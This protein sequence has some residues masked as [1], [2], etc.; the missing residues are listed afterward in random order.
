MP[1][2]LNNL[3]S[4][5]RT[6]FTTTLKLI[7]LYKQCKLQNRMVEEEDSSLQYLWARPSSCLRRITSLNWH[8]IWK[9][10]SKKD[11]LKL[12][13]IS[14]RVPF[15][16]RIQSKKKNQN[17]YIK[18]T[19]EEVGLG[20][21]RFSQMKRNLKSWSRM[22]GEEADRS[23]FQFKYQTMSPTRNKPVLTRNSNK[24]K[25]NKVW[26]SLNNSQSKPS[27]RAKCIWETTLKTTWWP[28][29]RIWQKAF[30][31]ATT[32]GASE[33]VMEST[34]VK[35]CKYAWSTTRT[36][37]PASMKNTTSSLTLEAKSTWLTTI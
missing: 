26:K 29:T 18:A 1:T 37:T 36:S 14:V 19:A 22:E 12:R 35:V 16:I 20:T 5:R 15:M 34:L 32:E 9:S 25:N 10:F 7:P 6:H 23:K 13:T 27:L 4:A 24:S 21:I 8:L 11:E 3:W 2:N 30:C 17:Q 33:A 28:S 31:S